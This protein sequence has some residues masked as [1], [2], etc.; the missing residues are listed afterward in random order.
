[1][2]R[3]RDVGGPVAYT[4]LDP[5]PFVWRGTGDVL[6]GTDVGTGEYPARIAG[7]GE[8]MAIAND[9]GAKKSSTPSSGSGG[10]VGGGR[11]AY[12]LSSPG[13]GSCRGPHTGLDGDSKAVVASVEGE[14]GG[15]GAGTTVP[16]KYR[17]TNG[18][19]PCM[20]G[21]SSEASV[22]KDSPSKSGS[23]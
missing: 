18:A 10:G 16:G 1:M 15:G 9:G 12:D 11:S 20:G 3:E 13:D 4:P 23:E 14:Y 19:G 2:A 21:L 5:D 6:T 7:I 22:W 8:D 17:G